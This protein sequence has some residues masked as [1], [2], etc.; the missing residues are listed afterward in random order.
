MLKYFFDAEMKHISTVKTLSC[1]TPALKLGTSAATDQTTSVRVCMDY[2]HVVCRLSKLTVLGTGRLQ[3]S[4][5]RSGHSDESM[6]SFCCICEGLSK[7][8]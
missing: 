6:F 8:V 5:D 2:L 3:I 1:D 4:Y 7:S